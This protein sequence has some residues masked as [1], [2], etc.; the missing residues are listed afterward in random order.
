MD[1]KTIEEA[2]NAAAVSAA[3]SD[4]GF[5]SSILYTVLG[6][7]IVSGFSQHWWSADGSPTWNQ[8]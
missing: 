1:L 7:S 8:N 2:A 5:D 6:V 3:I 4:P